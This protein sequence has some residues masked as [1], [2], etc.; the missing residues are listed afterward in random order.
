MDSTVKLGDFGISKMIE[1]TM[2]Q[3]RRRPRPAKL[4]ILLTYL[5]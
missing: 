1:G 2:G 4:S 5:I 3:A